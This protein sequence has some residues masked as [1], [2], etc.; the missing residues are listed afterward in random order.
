M[1]DG[2][3][4]PVAIEG[5]KETRY[6]LASDLPLLTALQEGR[7]PEAW[8]PLETTTSDEVTFLAPLEICSARGRASK[9]FGFDYVWEVY[10]PEEQRRWGYYVLPILYGDRLVARLD[11]RLERNTST[12]R[13][14]KFWLEDLTLGDDPAFGRALAGGIQRFMRFIGAKTLALESDFPHHLRQHLTV[15]IRPD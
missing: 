1:A 4:A 3:A 5:E 9:L 2:I 10:K 11:P 15:V 8:Q 6:A 14:L 13:I 7:I 12:L